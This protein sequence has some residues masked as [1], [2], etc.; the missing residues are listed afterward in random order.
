MRLDI[1]L[2]Y[3]DEQAKIKLEQ[4]KARFPNLSYKIFNSKEE[5]AYEEQIKIEVEKLFTKSLKELTL[6]LADGELTAEDYDEFFGD[7]KE[8]DEET[9]ED[10]D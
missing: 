2:G 7:M 3:L 4:F 8:E 9:E 10:E 1:D 5:Q 6:E